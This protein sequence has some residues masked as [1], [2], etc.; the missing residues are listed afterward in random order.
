VCNVSVVD[1]G[2]KATVAQMTFRGGE[3]PMEKSG[4]GAAYGSKPSKDIVNYVQALP[5]R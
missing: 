4:S 1:L 2:K 5:R 3:P